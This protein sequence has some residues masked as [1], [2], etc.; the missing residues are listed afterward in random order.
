LNNWLIPSATATLIASLALMLSYLILY[1]QEKRRYF[2]L[3]SAA[4]FI[5]SVRFVFVLLKI[6]YPQVA[7][8]SDLVLAM[9]FANSYL[10]FLSLRDFSRKKTGIIDIVIGAVMVCFI[11]SRYVF[12]IP[13]FFTTL[14]I[15]FYCGGIFIYKGAMIGFQFY[16]R[17][18]LSVLVG[19]FLVLWGLHKLDYPFLVNVTWFAPVGYLMGAAFEL[20]TSLF[21]IMMYYS[22]SK[23]EY[24]KDEN[25]LEDLIALSAMEKISPKDLLDK[26][27]DM[28]IKITESK[29]GYIYRY[30]EDKK[31]FTLNTWSK[32]VMH[33][34]TVASPETTYDLEKTGCWG[35]A[36]RQRK[37]YIINDY[38]RKNPLT[39]GTPA[40]HVTLK[41]F[42]TVPV[43]VKDRIKAVVGV[44]NKPYDYDA[45]DIRQLK[46]FMDGVWRILERQQR[47][48]ELEEAKDKAE[49]SARTKSVFLAN[50]SHELRTPLNGILGMAALLNAESLSPEQKHLVELLCKSGMDMHGIVEDLLDLTAIKEDKL[51]FHNEWFDFKGLVSAIV[52]TQKEGLAGLKQARIV[53][54][55]SGPDGLY[56]GDSARIAQCIENVLD[57][58]LK[59]SDEGIVRVD[60]TVAKAV[61]IEI[62]DSGIGISEAEL[63]R[64]FSEFVYEGQ[65]FMKSRR[66]LGLGLSITK[67]IME[68]MV[69]SIRIQ[70]KLGQG[71]IVRLEFPLFIPMKNKDDSTFIGQKTR[72]QMEVLVAEDDAINRLYITKLLK[73][74]G[75]GVL[76]AGNGEEVLKIFEKKIPALVLMDI[77]MPVMDGL[78]ATR[79]LKETALFSRVPIIAVTA[80]AL[81]S[82]LEKYKDLGME[83]I[84]K[85]FTEYQLMQKIDS[86]IQRNSSLNFPGNESE[87]AVE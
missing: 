86:L 69:G 26:A 37:P 63:S 41:K 77:G 85:P 15:F 54:S 12:G 46:I 22:L 44:A 10:L 83:F 71:T 16:S 5:Y 36:V 31:K 82:D 34:C 64:I 1:F 57:N 72:H 14:V 58:A 73:K 13:L 68:K 67:S 25:R 47:E 28:A 2:L 84:S 76:Q 40:G 9:A 78:Q 11:F 6:Y 87:I 18:K 21:I 56:H 66:G 55:W 42:L 43:L 75:Y 3:I 59:F 49:E 7:V 17:T 33:E 30:D 50:I 8:Y 35:E 29:I 79:K 52:N 38:S 39:K 24:R 27:L 74:N 4:W 65:P 61:I 60:V 51:V 62:K 19:C 48:I 81:P 23:N 45:G 32:E 70:S 20:F 53:H 80:H